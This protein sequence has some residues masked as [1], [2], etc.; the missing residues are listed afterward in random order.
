MVTENEGTVT[1]VFVNGA[2]SL[3]FC[4]ASDGCLTMPSFTIAGLIHGPCPCVRPDG[5]RHVTAFDHDSFIGINDG[6][7]VFFFGIFISFGSVNISSIRSFVLLS[8]S[9]LCDFVTKFQV[10]LSFLN[11][12]MQTLLS[13]Q[14]LLSNGKVPLLFT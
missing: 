6:M 1:G 13:L 4:K 2:P 9:L 8:L 5:T 11:F 14:L 7:Y 3:A 12:H 10:A